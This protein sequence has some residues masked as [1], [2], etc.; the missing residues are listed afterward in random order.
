MESSRKNK[1]T[2]NK[3]TDNSTILI[4]SIRSK[5]TT[6][7]VDKTSEASQRQHLKTS[8]STLEQTSALLDSMKA[9]GQNQEEQELE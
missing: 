7:V 3:S 6:P 1:M 2:E 4:A 5:N 9:K 8:K